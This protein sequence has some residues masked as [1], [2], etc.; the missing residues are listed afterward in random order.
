MDGLHPSAFLSSRT[1][2][3]CV[4]N[5][6]DHTLRAGLILTTFRWDTDV[7]TN[8]SLCPHTSLE[9]EAAQIPGVP[10][11]DGPGSQLLHLSHI[12]FP[13]PWYLPRERAWGRVGSFCIK[14]FLAG[15]CGSIFDH[16][17]FDEIPWELLNSSHLCVQCLLSLVLPAQETPVS[18]SISQYPHFLRCQRQSWIRKSTHQGIEQ[19]GEEGSGHLLSS[20]AMVALWTSPDKICIFSRK[21]GSTTIRGK[22]LSEVLIPVNAENKSTSQYQK[23]DSTHLFWFVDEIIFKKSRSL[24][25]P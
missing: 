15:S 9:A 22:I 1:I 7:I 12:D 5:L 2:Y 10:H 13:A 17:I 25:S 8:P 19:Q 6:I 18:S 20:C 14:S 21:C 16:L 24:N 11:T 4:S 3:R 23:I